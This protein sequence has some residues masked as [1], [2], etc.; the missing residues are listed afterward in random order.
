MKHVRLWQ[1]AFDP[2]CEIINFQKDYLAGHCNYGATSAFI[3]T[4]RDY[5]EGDEVVEMVLE[6]YPAMT[7]KQLYSIIEKAEGQW[8]LLHVLLSHRVGVIRPAEP[9]VL[10]A[11]WS[12]HRAAASDACRSIMEDL[13]H[14]APFWKKESLATGTARWVEKNTDGTS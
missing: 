7:E 9:I 4:M 1:E 13:K 10:V 12:A 11:V 3:G 8:P 2:W 6:H 5:N 14:Q